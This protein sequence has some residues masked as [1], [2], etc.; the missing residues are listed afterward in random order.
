MDLELRPTPSSYIALFCRP[1][2]AEGSVQGLQCRPAVALRAADVALADVRTG[3]CGTV[4]EGCSST[5][6][7]DE[8]EGDRAPK[9]LFV[10]AEPA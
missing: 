6:R 7:A 5:K 8:P 10:L 1:S 2:G 9:W 3:R 4:G